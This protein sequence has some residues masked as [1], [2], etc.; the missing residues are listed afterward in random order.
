MNVEKEIKTAILSL[1]A[2]SFVI[3]YGLDSIVGRDISSMGTI[4][5]LLSI[6]SLVAI[7]IISLLKLMGLIRKRD[8]AIGSVQTKSLEDL[9]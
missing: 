4:I 1:I 9:K 3:I 7:W 2:L 8:R 6:V 5:L